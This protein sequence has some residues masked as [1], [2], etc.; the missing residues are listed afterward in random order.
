MKYLVYILFS[1]THQKTYCGMT[2]HLIARFKSHN[3]LATK[4][5]PASSGHGKWF[6]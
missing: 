5:W 3:E 2:S 1:E 6:M 4:G